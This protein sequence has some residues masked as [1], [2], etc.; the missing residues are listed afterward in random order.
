MRQNPDPMECNPN[1]N[2]LDDL[3]ESYV[4]EYSNLNTT[5]DEIDSYMDVLEQKTDNL[6][7]EL[8]QLL[9]DNRKARQEFSKESAAS[10]AEPTDT[11]T[12]ESQ[13]MIGALSLQ[14][15]NDTTECDKSNPVSSND[16]SKS[17]DDNVTTNEANNNDKEI[18]SDEGSLKEDSKQ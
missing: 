14:V 1:P 16:H 6:Y 12:E 9:E 17:C 3:V 4:E 8:K 11:A 2:Q 7:S 5:M 18:S 15:M 13:E 10:A